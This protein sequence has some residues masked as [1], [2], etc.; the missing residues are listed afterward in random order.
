MRSEYEWRQTHFS[1]GDWKTSF[2]GLVA[3]SGQSMVRYGDQDLD[4]KAATTIAASPNGRHMWTVCLDHSIRAWDVTSGRVIA[5]LDL[6][7]DPDRD[8]DRPAQQ[9]LDPNQ[10]QLLSFRAP[11]AGH[12]DDDDLYTMVT[13][14]PVT[15]DF[16]FWAVD[17]SI[18]SSIDVKELYPDFRFRP[19]ID[20][21]TGSHGWRLEQYYAVPLGDGLRSHEW[22]LWLSVR[23]GPRYHV[24]TIDL[25]ANLP[26][27]RLQRTWEAAWSSVDRGR[28]T[29]DD[30]RNHPANPLN[31]TI[32][33]TATALPPLTE[34][35][36]NFLLSPG[37]FSTKVLETA[38]VVYQRGPQKAR[39]DKSAIRLSQASLKDRLC[40][41]VGQAATT[42]QSTQVHA[43]FDAQEQELAARWSIYY[44]L[45]NDLQKQ[46]ERPVALA[47]DE[48]KQVPWL[49]MADHV[50]SIRDCS[51]LEKLWHNRSAYA[52]AH[53]FQPQDPLL[54][55]LHNADDSQVGQLFQALSIFR[56][57]FSDDFLLSFERALEADALRQ[58][59]SAT[60]E[61]RLQSLYD[62]S[63][64]AGK[65]SDDDYNRVTDAL[66]CLGG[67]EEL[68]KSVFDKTIE[69][70]NAHQ[71]GRPQQK[72]INPYG[73]Q[74]MLNGARDALALG[75]DMLVDAALLVVFT[76]VELVADDYS[77]DLQPFDIFENI[78]SK[79]REYELLS[80]LSRTTMHG[81]GI[82]DA[83]GQ[84]SG[85]PVLFESLF[86]GDCKSSNPKSVSAM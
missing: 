36:V 65:V 32:G 73:C 41:A 7:G 56:K 85:S 45:V 11:R 52:A 75:H 71:H 68:G 58:D 64:F 14:S 8:F 23:A 38:L 69:F 43:A 15:Q 62:Q 1:T 9:L 72:E 13:Y 54:K 76:A 18:V 26:S 25:D 66:A 60:V 63:G 30:F 22:R 40:A 49:V 81:A 24:L 20:A 79:Y 31:Q 2:R 28:C 51:Q 17:A 6:A 29:A 46:R 78:S 53:K 4:P 37:R 44:G 35:W 67:F 84:D 42:A 47:F 74:T 10:P 48:H 70:L 82:P 27:K 77:E 21:L 34:R 16:K 57:G 55:T 80:W 39:Q 83:Q 86:G 59:Y 33:S 50:S 12:D 5:I 61:D 3:W 19:P